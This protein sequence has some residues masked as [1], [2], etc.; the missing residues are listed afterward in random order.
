MEIRVAGERRVK[1]A[2]VGAAA[3]QYQPNTITNGPCVKIAG[4]HRYVDNTVQILTL[5]Q[6]SARLESIIPENTRG[7]QRSYYLKKSST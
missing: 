2:P 7:S 3:P 4:R 6:T 1:M 5:E